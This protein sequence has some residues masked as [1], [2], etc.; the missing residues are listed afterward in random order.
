MEEWSKILQ[1]PTGDPTK[2][3]TVTGD[4]WRRTEA[5]FQSGLMDEFFLK[6]IHTQAWIIAYIETK[7]LLRQA[8]D[9]LEETKA[10][11]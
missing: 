4:F 9:Y 5:A 8:R 6:D 2:V 1:T 10:P 3:F 7:E 11:K